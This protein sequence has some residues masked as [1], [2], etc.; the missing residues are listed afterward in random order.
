MKKD[1]LHTAY[2]L[3]GAGLPTRALAKLSGEHAIDFIRPTAA[4]IESIRNALPEMSPSKI[5]GE[6]CASFDRDYEMIDLYNFAVAH[7][8]LPDGLIYPIVKAVSAN[9]DGLVKA[10]ALAKGIIA[11]NID[12]NIIPL[13]LHPG[14]A[15]ILL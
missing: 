8:D 3:S 12:R 2:C 4:Q 9:H 1:D 5:L 6:I 13:S 14:G 7:H 15:T 11:A 10:Q